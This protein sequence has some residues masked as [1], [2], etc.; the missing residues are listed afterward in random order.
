MTEVGIN[1][2]P[3]NYWSTEDPFIDRF[4]TSGAW[5]A[6]NGA[7]IALDSNGYPEGI[8]AGA[9]NIMAAVSVDSIDS[10]NSN[11]YTMTYDGSGNINILGSKILSSVNGT[12]T[13]QATSSIVVLQISSMSAT[14]PVSD[15]H[16]VRS[17]QMDL[18]KSGEIFNPAFIDKISQL[19]TIRFMDWENTNTLAP[20]SWDDRTQVSDASWKTAPIETMVALANESH[21]NMWFNIPTEADDAY[22]TQALTYIRDHL[23]PSLKVQ[24][25][26]SNEVWNSAFAA[27]GYAQAEGEQVLGADASNAAALYYGYR[28]AQIASIGKSVFGDSADARLDNV[29]SGFVGSPSW[30]AQ[31][32]LG[33]EKANLGSANSLFSDFAIANYFGLSTGNAADQNTILGW[34]QSGQAGIDAAFNEMLNG[35]TLSGDQSLAALAKLYVAQESLANTYGLNLVSYEG[36]VSLTSYQFSA[37]QQATV[38][39]FFQE[40]ANDPRMGTLYTKLIND[41]VAAGGD[42]MNAYNDAGTGGVWGQWGTLNDIYDSGSARFDALVAAND[43]TDTRSNVVLAD[44]PLAVNGT[45]GNDTFTTINNAI[46]SGGRATIRTISIVR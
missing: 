4:K 20:V 5:Q 11:I 37:S 25:E 35:G 8:P 42:A 40:L 3:I 39:A 15:I 10:G 36:G 44:G 45:S 16:I 7:T 41:F 2:A 43:H 24:V 14:D 26:Y 17:D 34:A 22:V 29:V 30:N 32:M 28:S 33:I 6:S 31:V 9:S 21:T 13:F 27:R 12:I 23:D 18:Y 46:I 38:T 1:L 19:D